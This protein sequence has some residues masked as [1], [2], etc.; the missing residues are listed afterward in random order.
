MTAPARPPVGH[1]KQA[2]DVGYPQFTPGQM[3][4]HSDLAA[5]AEY[6]RELSRLALRALFG[7]GVVCG[8]CVKWRLK[9]EDRLEVTVEPGIALDCAGDLVQ[10]PRST[11]VV[12][13]DDKAVAEAKELWVV[14]RG[15]QKACAPRVSA[16]GCDD[17]GEQLPAPFTR[18]QYFYEVQ[19]LR[20]RPKGSCGRTPPSPAQ[21]EGKEVPPYVD[22][23]A[24]AQ[25][26]YYGAS[27]ARCDCEWI[28]LARLNRQ[29]PKSKWQVQHE[30]R[31]FV[32]PVPMRDPG[33]PTEDE[34]AAEATSQGAGGKR[35]GG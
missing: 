18:L 24:D 33:C 8:L 4:H 27:C 3:L 25:P 9:C 22:P 19:L 2:S 12:A 30:V 32:R 31:R 6:T 34:V 1:V 35:E 17:D 21:S 10:V 28:V 23:Q 29:D 11:T 14:L 16:C 20:D 7:C 13:C 26:P 5:L 15:S